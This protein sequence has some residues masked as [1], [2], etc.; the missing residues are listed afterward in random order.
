LPEVREQAPHPTALRFQRGKILER[1]FL[2]ERRFKRRLLLYT[3]FMRLQ[4]ASAT[5]PDTTSG[6]EFGHTTTAGLNVIF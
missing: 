6:P 2:I 1:N 3:G 5:P 4:L